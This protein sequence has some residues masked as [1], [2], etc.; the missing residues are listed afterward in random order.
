MRI[1]IRLDFIFLPVLLFT[2]TIFSQD[3]KPLLNIEKEFCKSL[4]E[5]GLSNAFIKF[6][7]DDAIMFIPAPVNGKDYYKSHPNEMK[8]LFWEAEFAEI[9]LDGNFGYTTGPWYVPRVSAQ[10]DTTYT[11]GHFNTVWHKVNG[12]WKFLVDCGIN[13]SAG[14]KVKNLPKE[15]KPLQSPVPVIEK[16]RF[17]FE[18]L[19]Q[20][21]ND[22]VSVAEKEGLRTAYNKYASENIRAYRDNKAPYI[23]LI[24][25]AEIFTDEKILITHMGGRAANSGDYAFT[26]GT[27]SHNPE[28]PEFN[29]MKVWKR[30]GNQ[31][32]IVLDVLTRIN[33]K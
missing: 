10:G 22:F 31:W 33:K 18:E 1:Q 29:Y 3:I 2:G 20:L 5:I 9:S 26:F 4:T 17:P 23:G 21:D 7:D 8:T 13:Y 28:E 16:R 27:V 32:K 30:E 6:M 15:M 14:L 19:I 12:Q 25:A 24:N 11:H